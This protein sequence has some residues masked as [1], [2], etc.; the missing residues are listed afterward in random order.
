LL[1]TAINLPTAPYKRQNYCAVVRF[2]FSPTGPGPAVKNTAR[3]FK[4]LRTDTYEFIQ[5]FL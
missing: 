4:N 5:L 1:V 2:V 3:V